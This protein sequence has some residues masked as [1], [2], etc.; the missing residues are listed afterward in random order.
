VATLTAFRA[1]IPWA[2]AAH[3][4]NLLG[5]HDTARIRTVLGGD[6]GRRRAA[7]GLLFGYLGVPGLL[8]GDEIGL[9]GDSPNLARRTMPWAPASWDHGHLQLVRALA[10]QRAASAALRTGGLQVLEAGEDSLALLRDTDD[11]Q[12][13]VVV[14]RDPAGRPAGPLSVAHGAIADGTELVEILTGERRSVASG[15]LP[16]P[17]MAAGTAVWWTGPGR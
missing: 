12:A 11:E 7:F 14:A 8:Y 10:R 13:V 16:L 6:D 9:E 1:A 4:Y 2:V 17:A 15:R 5:S 3:Q